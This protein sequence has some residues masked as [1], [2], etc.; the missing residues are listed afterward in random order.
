[1]AL[2]DDDTALLLAPVRWYRWRVRVW[3]R[4]SAAAAAAPAPAAECQSAWSDWAEMMTAPT[5]GFRNTT[6]PIWAAGDTAHFALHR[7]VVTPAALATAS[8]VSRAVAFVTAQQAPKLLGAYKLLLDGVVVGIGPGR[9]DAMTN[10]TGQG[11]R[12]PYDALD[13]SAAVA[14]LAVGQ[15]WVVGLQCYAAQ[16]KGAVLLEMHL[17]HHDGSVS[18]VATGP[19]LG[20]TSFSADRAFGQPTTTAEGGYGAPQENQDAA[21]LPTGWALPGFT[22]TAAW[23]PSAAAPPI[24]TYPKPALALNVS[25]GRVPLRLLATSATSWFA[26]FGS[27]F[28]GGL[29]LVVDH[30]ISNLPAGTKLT[31]TMSEELEG[32]FRRS[33]TLLYPMRTGNKYRSVWTTTNG[34]SAF[35]HHEFM[36]F[37]YAAIQWDGGGAVSSTSSL[38]EPSAPESPPFTLTAWTVAYPYFEGESAFASSSPS[39]DAVWQLCEN[40]LRVTS[41]D[42]TTDSNTRERLPCQLFHCVFIVLRIYT[43]LWAN[44]V[45]RVAHHPTHH[46]PPPFVLLFYF[47]F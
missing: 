34:T 1:M 26:D 43:V 25:S 7:L 28:M 24:P 33:T 30:S 31:V 32:D 41:L 40:T 45:R 44:V 9:G 15:D 21:L 6:T 38:N 2:H 4:G 22:P 39:L 10:L 11:R 5:D 29:R 35:E 18:V 17:Q 8:P 42:T 36:E 23:A 20:W 13:V 14:G 3:T 12:V 19:G 37:R 47:F 27:E 16:G 46:P